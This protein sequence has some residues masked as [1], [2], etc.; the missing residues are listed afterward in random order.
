[1]IT[2]IKNLKKIG[3]LLNSEGSILGLYQKEEQLYLSSYLSDGSGTVFYSTD[4]ATLKRYLN[5]DLSLKELY[6]DS[7]DFLVLQNFRNENKTF[8]KEDL[9]DKIKFGAEMYEDLS[10]SMKNELLAKE[11]CL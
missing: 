2:D 6:V 3:D 4:G 5:S 11:Y 10:S 7:K 9:T 1:M 8:I